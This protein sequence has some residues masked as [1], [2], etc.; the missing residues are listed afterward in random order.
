[1]ANTENLYRAEYFGSGTFVIKK[2][3]RKAHKQRQT[4]VKN[5]QR[6]ARR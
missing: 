4:K 1:L 2:P 5:P 3:K 6:G